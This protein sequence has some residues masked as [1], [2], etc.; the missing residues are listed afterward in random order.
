VIA[1]PSKP[2]LSRIRRVYV[3]PFGQQVLACLLIGLWLLNVADLLLT[4]Y[5]LWLGFATESNDVMRYFLRVGT[6]T[7][8]VFKV[9]IVTIG[10]L[11]LWR[12]RRYRAAMF[13]AV[14]LAGIFAAVV[15]YQV[16]W[17]TSL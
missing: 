1:D 11:V 10:A 2:R 16:F 14:L 8:S 9:G 15:A 5:A 13:A 6:L 17:L 12:L 4:K 7:A 3:G